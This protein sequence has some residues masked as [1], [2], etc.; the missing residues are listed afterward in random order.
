MPRVTI[1]VVAYD[2]AWPEQFRRVRFDLEAALAD[3]PIIAIEH[4]G[5]TSVPGLAAK[6][7]LDI[8]V[9][10]ARAHLPATIA[11]LEAAGY[12][13][14]GDLG[15]TDRH[16]MEAPDRSPRRNVYVVVD[17][18]LA[19]R[20]HLALRDALRG[21]ARLR[22]A[23]AS[24]KIALAERTRDIGTYIAGKSDV[25]GRVLAGAGFSAADLAEIAAANRS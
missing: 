16:A 11:S 12:R 24:V 2:P 3:V 22:D 15:I 25:I 7:I 10:V 6:P 18:S 1:R 4:V 13:H 21:D 8:D 17:G 5:S 20:N 19:L 14:L 9:V 23:Y